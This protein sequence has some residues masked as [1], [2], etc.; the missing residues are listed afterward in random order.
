M[1]DISILVCFGIDVDK[2][3]KILERNL[4]EVIYNVIK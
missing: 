2:G 1:K 4:L 3:I